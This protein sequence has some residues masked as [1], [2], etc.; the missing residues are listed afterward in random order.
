[1]RTQPDNNS[2]WYTGSKRGMHQYQ[3]DQI[4]IRTSESS[5]KSLIRSYVIIYGYTRAKAQLTSRSHAISWSIKSTHT[6]TVYWTLF[7]R[8][9]FCGCSQL[10]KNMITKNFNGYIG[11]VVVMNFCKFSMK[12]LGVFA[13]IFR[14]KQVPVHSK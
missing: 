1:M 12:F 4:S 6:V 7:A 5:Y 14:H 13:N 11:I 3:A 2:R 8:E 9:H 10:Q